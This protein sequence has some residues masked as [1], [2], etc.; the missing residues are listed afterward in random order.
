MLVC[1]LSIQLSWVVADETPW[2]SLFNGTDL[3]GWRIV[4]LADPAPAVVEGGAMVLRQ[5]ENTVEHTFVTSEKKY[6]NFILELDLKDDP[7]FNSGILLR[8]VDAPADAHV[9]LNGY[10]IKI[11]NSQRSWTGGVFDDFGAGWTWL[12]DLKDDAVA[13]AAFKLGEWSHFRIECID[14]S[15]KVWVNGIPTCHLIDEKYR[16]GYIAFK[17]HSLGNKPDATKS[18]IRLKNIRLI[19]DRPERFAQPMELVARRAPT[20]PGDYDKK[21]PTGKP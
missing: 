4:A 3:D 18:A 2:V 7:S 21:L 9:R 10:Q 14:S 6:R 8:C 16:E 17:I 13:R 1:G 12:F 5:R 19:A 11:D 15:I 20:T